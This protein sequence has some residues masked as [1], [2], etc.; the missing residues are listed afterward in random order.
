MSFAS[1]QAI[2]SSPLRVPVLAVTR[3]FGI[4]LRYK[5]YHVVFVGKETILEGVLPYLLTRMGGLWELQTMLFALCKCA[6]DFSQILECSASRFI[7]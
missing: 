2:W 3:I 1:E 7:V 5:C 6:A 4:E